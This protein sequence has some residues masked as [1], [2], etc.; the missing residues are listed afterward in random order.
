MLC[1]KISG[2]DLCAQ[3]RKHEKFAD[4]PIVFLTSNSGIIDRIRAKIVGSSDFLK[5]TVDAD[6]LMQKVVEHLP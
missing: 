6:E 1:P 4:T 3:L 2:Y 5:K